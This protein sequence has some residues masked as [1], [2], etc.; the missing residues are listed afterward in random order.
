VI[1]YPWLKLHLNRIAN[2]VIG[3]MFGTKLN[4]TT[5]GFKAY[6]ATVIDGC[7]PLLSLHFNLTVELR[8]KTIVRGYRW[9]LTPITWRNRRAGISK[10]SLKETGSRYLFICLYMWLEKYFSHGDYKKTLTQEPQTREYNASRCAPKSCIPEN[11]GPCS[12]HS[13][14]STNRWQASCSCWKSEHAT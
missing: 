6:R 2:F 14:R 10:L 11:I 12:S 5:N 1:D 8:L 9:T 3:I 13:F 7:R 4:D